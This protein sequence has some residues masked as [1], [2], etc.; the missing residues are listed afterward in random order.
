MPPAAVSD[1][2]A[3]R[4][5]ALRSLNILD[6]PPEESFDR[7]TRLAMRVFGVPIAAISLVDE[8]RQWF[9]SAQ[10]L[11]EKETPRRDAFCS[12]AILGSDL[13]VVEDTSCD[14]RT[15]DSALTTGST[16]IRFYAGAPLRLDDRNT[17][18]A[19]CLMDRHPRSLAGA[20]ADMLRDFAGIVTDALRMRVLAARAEAASRAKSM[21][22]A[23]ISHEIRTPVTAVLGFADL[24]AD[25]ALPRRERHEAIETIRRNGAHLL[26]VISDILDLSKAEAN[27]L[28]ATRVDASPAQVL[29]DVL[30]VMSVRAKA[31]GLAFEVCWEGPPPASI[32][33]DPARLRQI[34]INLVGNAVKFTDRGSI[35]VT[36]RVDAEGDAAMLD[37]AITDT[38]IGMTADQVA[39]LFRP[40]A[41]VDESAERRFGGAGLGLALSLRLAELLGGGIQ[42]RSEPGQG[43]T[44]RVRVA[45]APVILAEPLP[46][47]ATNVSVPGIPRL[48]GLRILLVEDGVDN[49]R[50]LSAILTKAGAAVDLA[51]NGSEAL[52]RV[53]AAPS[54]DLAYDVILMDIQMP[55]M[56]GY[57][58]TRELRRRGCTTPILALTAHAMKS[59]AERSLHAGC[60]E[61]LTK[62]IERSKLFAAI[63]RHAARRH[64]A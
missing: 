61:H 8:H 11:N 52:E 14:P 30:S 62:P 60:N 63:R 24:L 45:A 44:F 3:E 31:K 59:D 64:A 21:F 35:R 9:K 1:H 51:V 27:R 15:L 10:G 37:V 17:V 49:Q 19:M 7:I 6:T 47:P 33:T 34:L 12:H 43:S 42:V 29:A 41:Q 23:N 28:T 57:T 18:G 50:L 53:E 16:G 38:G 46:P 26:Q 55:V 40:F 36:A 32:R 22:L 54:V 58:A 25:P 39:A 13:M 5:A 2:E 4:L 56:D 48:D 20:D